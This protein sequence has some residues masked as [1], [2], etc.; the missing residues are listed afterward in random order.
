M[1]RCFTS[2]LLLSV[3]AF[4]SCETEEP[5]VS[6]YE[7]E[8]YVRN[9]GQAT[10]LRIK[11]LI[12]DSDGFPCEELEKEADEF[13]ARAKHQIGNLST[14]IVLRSSA[15]ATPE[16]IARADA[17]EVYFEYSRAMTALYNQ[18]ISYKK[19]FDARTSD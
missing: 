3:L 18:C 9:D 1:N 14:S 13:R 6:P 2:L 12:R 11:A 7:L 5:R 17:S 16:S 15:L 10:L 19:K 4:I 8:T